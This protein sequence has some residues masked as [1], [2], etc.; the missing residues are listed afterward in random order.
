MHAGE[1]VGSMAWMNIDLPLKS[2][3]FHGADACRFVMDK[4]ETSHKGVEDLRRDGGWMQF[5]RY[6]QA[7]YFYREHFGNFKFINHCK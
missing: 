3:T 1:E 6:L 2:C 4:G 5:D 7:W